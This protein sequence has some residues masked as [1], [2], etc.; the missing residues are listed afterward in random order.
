MDIVKKKGVKKK[1]GRRRL[2][3]STTTTTT[4]KLPLQQGTTLCFQTFEN[5]SQKQEI[6]THTRNDKV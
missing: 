6:V 5:I 4:T 2:S 3:T 1:K